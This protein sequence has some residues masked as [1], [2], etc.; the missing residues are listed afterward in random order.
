MLATLIAIESGSRLSYNLASFCLHCRSGTGP[1]IICLG[2]GGAYCYLRKS[3]G[4]AGRCYETHLGKSSKCSIGIDVI[5]QEFICLTC[6]DVVRPDDSELKILSKKLYLIK[7][8][9]LPSCLDRTTQHIFPPRGFRNLGNSCYMNVI[10]QILL[11]IPELQCYFLMDHHNRDRQHATEDEVICCACELVT[12]LQGTVT[13]ER[14]KEITP[15]GFLY[16]LWMNSGDGEDFAGYREADAHE[17]LL[18]CLNQ[19]HSST[20]VAS[21]LD[22]TCHCPIHA[23]FRCE[24]KSE[25]ICGHCNS[26]SHKVDP[27]LDLSLE[28]GHLAHLEKLK[29]VDCLESFTRTEAL[30]EKGYTCTECEVASGATTKSLKISKLSH[31]LCIQLKRFEH[32]GTS[33]KLDKFVQFPLMLDM[34]PYT[35]SPRNSKD[36]D[37]S[38]YFYKLTG[39]VRHQGN[40]SSGHYQA[41]VCQDE[42]YFCFNDSSVNVMKLKDVLE[43]EAYILVYSS[44]STVPIIPTK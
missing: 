28:I 18:A 13:G 5:C 27:I 15:V 40:A 22:P 6:G 42:L 3:G 21:A 35:V 17:C 4:K 8:P 25:L 12:I 33:V 1:K 7:R 19:L 23:L 2:C 29:L 36:T 24:L 43:T 11:R 10:L 20:Q 34:R 37:Q 38:R 30:K 31:L 32:R 16:S 41:I 9:F 39:I 44:V 14:A 26:T